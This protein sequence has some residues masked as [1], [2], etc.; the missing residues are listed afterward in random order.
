LGTDKKIISNE[1]AAGFNLAFVT[2]ADA[3]VAK[4][5]NYLAKGYGRMTTS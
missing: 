2:S 4:F 3:P 1:T 5:F